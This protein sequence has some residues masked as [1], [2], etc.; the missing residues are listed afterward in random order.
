M[1]M[2]QKLQIVG[3]IALLGLVL[4]WFL[5]L[6]PTIKVATGYTA[7]YVCSYTFLSD[8]TTNHIK[9]ALNF[10]PIRYVRYRVDVERKE[11]SAALLGIFGRQ[12]VRFYNTGTQ[13]GCIVGAQPEAFVGM[14]K[15]KGES[16][17]KEKVGYWPQGER[18]ADTIPP[19]VDLKSLEAIVQKTLNENPST[20]AIV[21]AHDNKLITEGYQKGVGPDTRLLGWSMT[22][23]IANALF[24]ILVK[25]GRITL[26]QPAGLAEWQGDARST[27]T[28]NELLQMRS[29]LR[30]TED[31]GKLS[32]VTR[33]LYLKRDFPQVAIQAPLA[34]PVGSYWMYSS[35]TSNILSKIMRDQFMDYQEYLQFPKDSLFNSINMDSA[36]IETDA[37]GNFVLS[38]YC[39]AT[40]R[41]WTKFGLLY[42]N[43]GN[44]FGQQVLPP[45][46]VDYSTSPTSESKGTYGAQI[47]L[48]HAGEMKGVPK[49]AFYESGFGGQRILIVPSKKLVITVMSG[50]QDGF[51]FS[52]LY[53]AIFKCFEYEPF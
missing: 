11:V 17:P 41:D 49:T 45:D 38:S 31:Y 22:K 43:K 2:K 18:I 35:G 42:L 52:P 8:I 53:S 4:L 50:K 25:S 19:G 16:K 47:W 37:T 5:Y 44:W 36:L 12:T 20:L 3:F 40:A 10:F 14:S 24:G 1:I 39:W 13:C 48:N 29:G 26:D 46:W 23:T 30:W 34:H 32:D 15:Q 51:E 27:I 7:K 21:I 33:M 28:I 9:T 6:K